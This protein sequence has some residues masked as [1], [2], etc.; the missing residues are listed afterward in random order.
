MQ[1]NNVKYYFPNV[2]FNKIQLIDKLN[3]SLVFALSKIGQL[4]QSNADKAAEFTELGLEISSVC[5]S[6][7]CVNNHFGDEQ[8]KCAQVDL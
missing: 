2:F 7:V 5:A 3:L 6:F 8:G 1:F 4:E